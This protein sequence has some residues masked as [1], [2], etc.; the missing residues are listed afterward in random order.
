MPA[1]VGQHFAPSSHVH[2]GVHGP[3]IFPTSPHMPGPVST[4]VVGSV[5]ND[6]D[7]AAVVP[8]LDDDVDVL[9]LAA[10]DVVGTG[11]VPLDSLDDSTDGR[12]CGGLKH[13][14]R[15]RTVARTLRIHAA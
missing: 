6:V 5:T 4:I 11:G 13:D 12:P 1:G 8:P 15:T 7:S 10:T 3:L 14:A 9:V 2:A